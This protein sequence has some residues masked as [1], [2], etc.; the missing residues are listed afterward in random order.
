MRKAKKLYKILGISAI[1]IFALILV[2]FIAVK[3]ILS[4][5]VLTNLVNKYANEYLDARVKI[6]S[7]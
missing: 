6:D 5:K 2:L 4:D 1:S 3:V 7:V